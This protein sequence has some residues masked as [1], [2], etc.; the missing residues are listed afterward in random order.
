MDTTK[1]NPVTAHTVDMFFQ[2]SS[3]LKGN[4]IWGV[5]LCSLIVAC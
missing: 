2:I 3:V 1:Q 4:I 5:T